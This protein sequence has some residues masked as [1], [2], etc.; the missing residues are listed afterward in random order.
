M[1]ESFIFPQLRRGQITEAAP[2][3]E[4]KPFQ[5]MVT[6][7]SVSDLQTLLASMG[8]SKS[9]LRQDLV[10]RALLLVQTECSPELLMNVRQ[11]YESPTCPQCVGLAGYPAPDLTGR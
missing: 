2:S 5:N 3:N 11:L 10:G 6:S 1:P 7:F 8:R 4:N 9:G